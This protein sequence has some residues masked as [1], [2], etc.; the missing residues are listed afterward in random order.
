M[1]KLVLTFSLLLLSP[2]IVSQAISIGEDGIVRCKGVSIGST[3]LI[4]DTLYEVVDRE[5]LIQRR[6]ECAD[7]TTSCVS[8]VTTMH[9]LF[10]GK[11]DFNQAIGNWDVQNVIYMSFFFQKHTL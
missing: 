8:N 6:D 5:L 3:K 11:K 7:L 4:H 10:N 1:T 2:T 9:V